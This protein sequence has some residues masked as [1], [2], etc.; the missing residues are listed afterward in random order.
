MPAAIEALSSV[1]EFT[2]S[3]SGVAIVPV[4]IVFTL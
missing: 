3:L 1:S 4:N 2:K